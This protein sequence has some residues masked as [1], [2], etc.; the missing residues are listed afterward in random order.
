[1]T[2]PPA[3][4]YIY[5]ANDRL[6]SPIDPQVN[7]G[8]GFSLANVQCIARGSVG[9][10]PL[11]GCW[12]T[13]TNGGC[14]KA[15]RPGRGLAEWHM[16]PSWKPPAHPAVCPGK[17]LWLGL[18]TP[19]RSALA[20]LRRPEPPTDICSNGHMA[21]GRLGSIR[22]QGYVLGGF[23]ILRQLDLCAHEDLQVLAKSGGY[24]CHQDPLGRS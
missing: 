1:M 7:A 4:N 23:E 11:I 17:L 10:P 9:S 18:A 20:C 24:R 22:I 15:M 13:T 3:F 21:V 8:D 5:I 6:A 14:H 16:L 2:R 12:A 19:R